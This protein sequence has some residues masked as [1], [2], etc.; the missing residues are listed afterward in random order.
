MDSKKITNTNCWTEE[1]VIL[2]RFFIIWIN[3]ERKRFLSEGKSIFFVDCQTL[4]CN[5]N[6]YLTLLGPRPPQKINIKWKHAWLQP[7]L[8]YY[9]HSVRTRE[10]FIS[11]IYTLWWS[12]D[13][14]RRP[15]N[16]KKSPTC[17]DVYSV[18]SKQVGYF[19][20]K[21]RGFSRK[22]ELYTQTWAWYTEYRYSSKY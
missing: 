14:L 15:Q 12:S 20:F 11:C 2:A 1:K 6:G 13:F 16:L 17:F 10:N 4:K 21:F 5:L 19:F 7:I 22:P 8:H 9:L 3:I 18:A